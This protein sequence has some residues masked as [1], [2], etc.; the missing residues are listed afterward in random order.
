M[1]TVVDFRFECEMREPVKQWLASHGFLPAVEVLIGWAI[2]D[3]LAGRYGARPAR[4]RKPPL[5]ECWAVELKLRDAA[6]VIHQAKA[7]LNQADRSFCAM[8]ASHCH[9]M[10]PGTVEK[11]RTNGVGLLSVG[12]VVR[13]IVPSSTGHGP[14]PHIVDRLWRRVRKLYTD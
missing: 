11:F 4:R 2:I 6:G 13:Q 8:P 9:K 12:D 3:I 14:R 1:D 7:N 10:R 5:L